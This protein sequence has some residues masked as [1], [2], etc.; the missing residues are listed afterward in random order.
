[1]QI[2]IAIFEILHASISRSI[3]AMF[4]KEYIIHLYTGIRTYNFLFEDKVQILMQVKNYMLFQ[5]I[6]DKTFQRPSPP[7]TCL[8]FDLVDMAIPTC[9]EEKSRPGFEAEGESVPRKRCCR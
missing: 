8:T 5:K 2:I 3:N 4:S 6:A 1:M 9:G 7:S